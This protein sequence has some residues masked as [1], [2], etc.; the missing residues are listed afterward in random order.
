MSKRF[1][2]KTAVRLA[3]VLV[4]SGQDP[5]A[6]VV[7]P[8]TSLHGGCED[9]GCCPQH[10]GTHP[11]T[12]EPMLSVDTRCSASELHRLAHRLQLID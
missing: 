2:E 8:T 12:G 10:P 9:P 3:E 11:V 7:P 4:T 5:D 6:K 1:K